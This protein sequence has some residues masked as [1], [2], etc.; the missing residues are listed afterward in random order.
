MPQPAAFKERL[1]HTSWTVSEERIMES[2]VPF[3]SGFHRDMA[4][5]KLMMNIFRDAVISI[6][7]PVNTERT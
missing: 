6:L 7:Y 3:A 4:W 5:V 1:L 2:I